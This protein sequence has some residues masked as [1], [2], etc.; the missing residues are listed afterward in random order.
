V[1]QLVSASLHSAT[2]ALRWCHG[3]ERAT[4]AEG[5]R[6]AP[7]DWPLRFLCLDCFLQGSAIVTFPI[8]RR[9]CQP[10]VLAQLRDS[11]ANMER[12]CE[13]EKGG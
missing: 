8:T 11:S 2:Y 9:V 6:R 5:V 7:F 4:A 13:R 12:V 10:E 1:G 3:V